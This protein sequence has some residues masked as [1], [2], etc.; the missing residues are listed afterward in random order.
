MS[1][2]LKPRLISQEMKESYINYAM[3]VIVGRA[4]PNVND[5]LKPVHRRI[6]YAMHDLGMVHNKPSKKSARIVGEVIGK[7]HPHGDSAVYDSLVRMAQD[8]SLRYPLIKGQGNFGSIDGDSPA[9]MRYTEAKLDKVA[10]ELLKDI[11]K[12]TVDFV[13]NFDDQLKEPSVLPAKLPNLLIN[14]SSGIAVGMATNMPPHNISET[15]SAI[16]SQVDNPEIT[17]EELMQKIPGP[18]FPTGGQILGRNGIIKAYKTGRGIV[19][20]RGVCEVQENK[21]II[22]EIPYQ[23]NKTT[24]IETIAN[25]VR[26][27]K[28]M[29]ISDIRDESDRKGMRV[30]ILLKRDANGELILNQLYRH[31]QLAGTF[32]I[33]NLALVNDQ[34]RTLSLKEIIFNFIKHRRTIITRRT[35]FDLNKAETRAHILI[36]LK[37]AL[38]N[39][40]QVVK[41]IKQSENVALAKEG[42]KTNFELSEEQSKAILE[43]KLQKLTSLETNKITEEYTGL[44]KLISELKEILENE[45]RISEIIKTELEE[46]DNKY[47]GERRTEIIDIDEAIDDEDLIEKEDCV[48]TV[49]HKGYVNRL[50]TDTY[51]QQARGGKGVRATGTREEDFVENLFTTNTHDYLM[52]FSNTGKV[53]WSKAYTIPSGSRYSKGM[54]LVN[55]LNLQKDERIKSIIPIAKFEESWYLNMVTKNGLIKKTSLK[56]YSNPRKG[57]IIA[58]NLKEGDSLIEVILTQDGE[59]LIVASKGGMAV[60]FKGD[61]IR[62]VGRNSMGV[63]AI[64]LVDDEVIGVTRANDTLLTITE[65]GYGKRTKVD[66]YRLINRGGKGVIN[67]KT[68]ERNGKVAGVR[69]VTDKDDLIFVTQNGILIRTSAKDISTIGRNTQ[70][71]R[72]MKLNDGDKVISVAK[73]IGED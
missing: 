47:G 32:G 5:G 2:N 68:S 69:S 30:V 17:D 13:P 28:V 46:M 33:N 3:S 45:S 71:L 11:E 56:E 22:S 63:R 4:L 34:P 27:K 66:D 60:K 64:R 67:I 29:G 62:P 50:P 70:G 35:Q 1:D 14:G 73:V 42:L 65:N 72:I 40:D 18:D 7:Y 9:A 41:T 10:E 26:N 51:R 15:I 6:L 38:E 57:G 39:I 25:L 43:M 19:K 36:G 21:I 48:V 23:V 16:I 59:E 24:L 12:D 31:T 61:Q 37:K 58:I 53:Y 8:F 20:V 54:H 52:F 49:T 55:L 44:L